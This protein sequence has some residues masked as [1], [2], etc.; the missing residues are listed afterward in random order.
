[1]S[2]NI[3]IPKVHIHI[4]GFQLHVAESSVSP[5][6]IIFVVGSNGS[7]KTTFL[8]YISNLLESHTIS[9]AALYMPSQFFPQEGLT[10]NDLFDLFEVCNSPYIHLPLLKQFKIEHLLKVPLENL[11]S[12]ER[13]KIFLCAALFHKNPIIAFDEP[14]SFLDVSYFG[15]LRS[16]LEMYAELGRTFFIS[17][18]DLNWSLTFNSSQTWV[19]FQNQFAIRNS[20]PLVLSDIK[21]NEVFG[22]QLK[23]QELP[24]GT[25]HLVMK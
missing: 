15:V 12:G 22:V 7:G 13:Q 21:L 2:K 5:G 25:R 11:S 1:M 17:N 23:L 19:L 4:S 20:T 9:P 14:L 3:L 18:H 8:K 10:G 6:Q 24:D 16:A